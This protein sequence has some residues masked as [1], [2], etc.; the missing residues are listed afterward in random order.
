MG[1]TV[2]SPFSSPDEL[3]VFIRETALILMRSGREAAASE[4]S[5][6]TGTAWTTSSE[7]LGELGQAVRRIQAR[8][9]LPPDVVGRLHRIMEAVHVA[10]PD[11]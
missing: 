7:W 3:D 11:L 2:P 10:W 8:A 6:V 1:V 5:A 4:L 9:D